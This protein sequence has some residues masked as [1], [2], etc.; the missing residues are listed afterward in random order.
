M[1]KCSP[2]TR[3]L[4]LMGQVLEDGRSA[5]RGM[6]LSKERMQNPDLAFSRIPQELAVQASAGFRAIVEGTPRSMHPAVRDEVYCIGREAVTNA[7][8]H[9]RATRIEVQLE[10]GFREL[11]VLVRD[12]GCGIDSQALD[13]GREGQ[14]GLSGMRERAERIG[15]KLRVRSSGNGGTEV[16]LR[17]PDR[18]AFESQAS[19]NVTKWL[20]KMY[21]R[22]TDST[23]SEREKRA[24]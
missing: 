14:W 4:E 7:F 11:R 5:A 3:V 15:A 8:R 16:D 21:A 2:I 6:R 23:A 1:L 19:G 17:V 9:S 12:N 20:S 10:Y 18:I 22:K 13:F 24:G